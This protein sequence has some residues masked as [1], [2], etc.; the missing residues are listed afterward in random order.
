QGGLEIT[1]TRDDIKVPSTESEIK[2]YDGKRIGYVAL[3]RFGDTTTTEVEEQ[4]K[5]FLEDKVDA[6]LIDVRF[7]GGG[8]LEKAVD[9][10]S[11]F[12][13]KGKVV[14]VARREGEL[15]HHYVSGRPLDTEIPLAILI[16]EG[17]ASA[18]EILAGVLQDAGRA[19]IVGKQSF[20]K[21]TV[22]EVFELPGGTSLR[23][24][25]ARWLTPNGR[26]LGKDGVTPDIEVERTREQIQKKE[27]PQLDA[28][29]ELLTKGE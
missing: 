17:S 28:A 12:I 19:T 3:N 6:L 11:M 15:S 23:V 24:T 29:L 5:K 9:L 10:T 2:E 7:N 22:Q 25:T 16:N 4:V 8:Y 13:Q 21:G 14:S 1:I 27:D 26:D 20:G 18:S